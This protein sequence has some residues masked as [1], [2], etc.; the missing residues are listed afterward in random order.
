M[1]GLSK[2]RYDETF[3]GEDAVRCSH[4]CEA[5]IRRAV[6]RCACSYDSCG[7]RAIKGM[8]VARRAKCVS[9]SSVVSRTP[10]VSCSSLDSLQFL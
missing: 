10:C 7:S 2:G 1:K 5:F 3:A 9:A 4:A 6:A 8:V